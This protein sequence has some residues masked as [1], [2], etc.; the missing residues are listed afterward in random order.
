MVGGPDRESQKIEPG[1][2]WSNHQLLL[3]TLPRPTQTAIPRAFWTQI[4]VRTDSRSTDGKRLSAIMPA[5]SIWRQS[6]GDFSHAGG[7]Q[8]DDRSAV[9]TVSAYNRPV[10]ACVTAISWGHSILMQSAR[11]FGMAFAMGC[12][13]YGRWFL[14]LHSHGCAGVCFPSGNGSAPA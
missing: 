4:C 10:I 6:F 3:T 8:Q 14:A 13:S 12:I 1:I 9:L 2:Q 11:R 7:N 5:V